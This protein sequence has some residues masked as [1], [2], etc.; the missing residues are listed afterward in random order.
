MWAGATVAAVLVAAACAT[1]VFSLSWPWGLSTLTVA[2]GVMAVTFHRMSAL[3]GLTALGCVVV[4]LQI[5][6]A[7]T[8]TVWGLLPFLVAGGAFILPPLVTEE[9]PAARKVTLATVTASFSVTWFLFVLGAPG[10]ILLI[11]IAVL[12]MALLLATH[13]WHRADDEDSNDALV[14]LVML[15]I[16]M[17]LVHLVFVFGPAK[18]YDPPTLAAP[19][20][21]YYVF[22]VIYIMASVAA[23]ARRDDDYDLFRDEDG[24]TERL[25]QM[26]S[27]PMDFTT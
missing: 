18:P 24:G 13:M 15:T 3:F 2:L 25:T 10:D 6:S 5:V 17:H 8:V 7:G 20:A 1:V 4:L 14:F 11:P 26:K 19:L 16:V 21:F 27:F 9:M 23:A 22:V 12:A